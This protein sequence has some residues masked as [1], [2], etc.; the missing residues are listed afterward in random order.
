MSSLTDLPEVIGFFS[1]SRDDDEDFGRQL[2]SLRDAIQ[3]ELAAAL[4]LT[5]RNFHLWQ[6][7]E[8]IAPGEMWETKIAAAINEAT[9]FI[10]IVTPRA[11]GSDH[12]KFEF[13]AFLTCEQALGRSNLI[14]PILYI[15]VTALTEDAKWRSDPV[16]SVIGA[17]Q[18]VDWRKHRQ[19]PT[20]TPTYREA[21]SDFCAKIADALSEPWMSAEERRQRE[22]A[23]SRRR[24][25]EQEHREKEAWAAGKRVEEEVRRG[26][27]EVEAQRRGAEE[28]RRRR[29]A[30]EAKEQAEKEAP[31]I[32]K[33]RTQRIAVEVVPNQTNKKDLKDS[34]SIQLP[35][36]W[37][38][39][40]AILLCVSS[41]ALALVILT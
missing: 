24:A 38:R 29:H 30:V 14:F 8:A 9:F 3:K 35:F 18:F 19:W 10:P 17:R 12:C 32:Q 40:M 20:E 26:Q 25:T 6:D 2:S 5:K 4:G 37:V 31:R 27:E 22:G 28:E 11:V 16:L 41:V 34:K 21:I 33:E 23:E 39:G 36:G 13:N 15:T 1:Y 7:Q